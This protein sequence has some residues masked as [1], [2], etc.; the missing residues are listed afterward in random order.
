M[1]ASYLALPDSDYLRECFDYDPLGGVLRWRDRPRRHFANEQGHVRFR[2]FSGTVAGCD[3]DGPG[4]VVRLDN[5]LWKASRLIWKLVT[6]TDP[7]GLVDHEDGDNLNNRWGNLRDATH[8]QNSMNTRKRRNHDLP[9]GVQRCRRKYMTAI[10]VDR[11]RVHVGVFDTVA[12]AKAAYDA[13]ASA[14]FGEFFRA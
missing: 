10:Y 3:S 14:A 7:A 1:P 11:R 2:R 13:A 6:G 4:V 12:E 9:K 8:A 5:H